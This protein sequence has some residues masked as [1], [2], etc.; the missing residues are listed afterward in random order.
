MTEKKKR[1]TRM[2]VQQIV[3]HTMR[4]LYHET[5]PSYIH[6]CVCGFI[7]MCIYVYVYIFIY[8]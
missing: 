1:K 5:C 4:I 2:K 6:I 8:M 7:D 3:I